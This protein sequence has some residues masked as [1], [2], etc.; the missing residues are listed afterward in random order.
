MR[1]VPMTILAD[2]LMAI[3]SYN[4]GIVVEP[5]PV[6]TALEQ[7][8]AE[9]K[10]ICDETVG[11]LQQSSA[12]VDAE[13]GWDYFCSYHAS[14]LQELLKRSVKGLG[15]PLRRLWGWHFGLIREARREFLR[16]ARVELWIPFAHNPLKLVR[17]PGRTGKYDLVN[18]LDDDGRQFELGKAIVAV[19]WRSDD[20]FMILPSGAYVTFNTFNYTKDGVTWNMQEALPKAFVQQLADFQ[21]ELRF[22]EENFAT[23]RVSWDRKNQLAYITANSH[24]IE[25]AAESWRRVHI[26]DRQ[27]IDILRR[28]ELFERNDLAAPRGLLLT[29]PPGTGKTLVA[30]TL[31]EMM[32]CDFQMLSL[33]DLKDEKMGASGKRVREV[34]DRARK[35]QPAIIFIDECEGILGRRGAAETD[36]F[37]T[38]IV[39]AFLAEWDGIRSNAQVW[40]IGATSRRDMLDDAI[41]SRFGWEIELKLPGEDDRRQILSQEVLALGLA[42]EVPQ[43]AA[44]LTQGMSGRDLKQLAQSVRAIAYPAE[45]TREHF[46]EAIGS[47]RKSH[48]TKVDGRAVWETLVLDG[49]ILDRLKLICALLR[50]AERWQAQGVSIPRSLLLAGPSGVGKTQVARTLANESGLTFLAATTA[51]VKANYLGQS[52]NRVKLLFE[53]ARSSAPAILFLD[54]LDVI[55]PDRAKAGGN[56]Q[57]TDE[58]VGQLLQEMDGIHARESH[59]FLAAATNHLERIDAAVRSRFQEKLVVPL[60]DQQ[61][62]IRLLTNLLTGKKISF[63][64]NDGAVLLADQ[65]KDRALSGRDLES[66]V[67]A[68][69]QKALLRALR[70]GGPGNFAIGLED[71]GEQFQH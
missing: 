49:A 14:F 15:A 70:E 4:D 51:D 47:A 63:S 61:A 31:R 28:A 22:A 44:E 41:L 54:E 45:P 55:A 30:R 10:R 27:K 46:F 13:R 29:G 2:N 69:E 36:A 71:F 12:D 67:Q 58:I 7:Y 50:D 53:R 20:F 62:R 64:L 43:E 24:R 38:D 25:K 56:D 21:L 26:P 18:W 19:R 9:R 34:W 37:A 6:T 42:V 33:A 57:L 39:H 68:A 40:V 66:W 16:N 1:E 65:T 5:S 17:V 48:N 23:L 8:W 11:Q 32:N 35:Y 60:P 3:S 59:V 52:G